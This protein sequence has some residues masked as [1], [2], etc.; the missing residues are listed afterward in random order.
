MI[1]STFDVISTIIHRIYYMKGGGASFPNLGYDVFYEFNS[2]ML[3]P[4][5]ILAS[6]CTNFYLFIWFV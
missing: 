4:C 3:H 2:F 5:T 1:F 6:T